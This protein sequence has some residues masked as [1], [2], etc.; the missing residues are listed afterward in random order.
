MVVAIGSRHGLPKCFD[1]IP[2]RISFTVAREYGLRAMYQQL[3]RAFK[4]NGSPGSFIH[5]TNGV[6]QGCTMSEQYGS[7]DELEGAVVVTVH[8]LPLVPPTL[9]NTVGQYRRCLTSTASVRGVAKQDNGPGRRMQKT[10]GAGMDKF[11]YW[12]HARPR[13]CGHGRAEEHQEEH[14]E[15]HSGQ[16]SQ[17]KTMKM[18]RWIPLLSAL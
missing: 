16:H 4:L 5:A 14:Q 12:E 18:Q 3:Q 13:T 15:E 11:T 6:L 17:V 1:L 8:S 9:Q 10:F 2:Q 7:V